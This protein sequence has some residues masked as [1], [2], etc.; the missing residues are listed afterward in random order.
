MSPTSC[1]RWNASFVR[2]LMSPSRWVPSL[3]CRRLWS[4]A[5]SRS[6]FPICACLAWT[7]SSFSPERVGGQTAVRGIQLLDAEIHGDFYGPGRD[8]RFELLRPQLFAP[9]HAA[10]AENDVLSRIVRQQALRPA[11]HCLQTLL[12]T[13][14][15]T[16]VYN[17]RQYSVVKDLDCLSNQFKRASTRL[18]SLLILTASLGWRGGPRWN[19][20]IDLTLI[21]GA[22]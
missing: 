18:N 11:F 4:A 3:G 22:L 20:T 12:S 16:C 10:A 17:A 6:S 1:K 5:H 21:R 8:R 7:A 9:G 2:D 14:L 13:R 19:R 15:Y